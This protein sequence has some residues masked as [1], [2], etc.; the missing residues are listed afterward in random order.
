M[1]ASPPVAFKKQYI[2]RHIDDLVY[3]DR[4]EVLTLLRDLD[5]DKIKSLATGSAYNLDKATPEHINR[6]FYLVY[7]R[8]NTVDPAH[9]IS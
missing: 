3:D 2:I 4:M 6:V 7:E 9:A 5:K 8:Y 1:S